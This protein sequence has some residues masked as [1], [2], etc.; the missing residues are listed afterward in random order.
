M[1][2][3]RAAVSSALPEKPIAGG[4]AGCRLDYAGRQTRAEALSNHPY[5]TAQGST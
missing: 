4:W 5:N 3:I 2:Q 1:R